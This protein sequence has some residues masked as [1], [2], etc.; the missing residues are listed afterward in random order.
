MQ[1]IQANAAVS[2]ERI[3]SD[4]LTEDQPPKKRGRPRKGQ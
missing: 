3:E 2:L 4:E 1:L